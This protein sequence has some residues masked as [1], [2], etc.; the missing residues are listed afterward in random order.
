MSEVK[1]TDPKTGGQKGVKPERYD[2]IPWDAMDEIARVYAFGA[3]KYDDHN[4]AKGYPWGWSLAA[5][6]RHA[7][8]F[9][10]GEDRDKESGC[11]HLA[12]VAWHCLTMMMFHIK[13]IGRDTR[14]RIKRIPRIYSDV[15]LV[16]NGVELEEDPYPQ[17]M[18]AVDSD[19]PPS[20]AV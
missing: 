20:G 16:I 2:L 13:G 5:L 9:A 4:W 3:T 1:A 6:F 15:H 19:E 14:L 12:H 8:L 17:S 10:R 7:S 18:S 11:L